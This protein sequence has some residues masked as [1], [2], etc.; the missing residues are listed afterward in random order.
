MCPLQGA[1][2]HRPEQE[3]LVDVALTRLINP[4]HFKSLY[5]LTI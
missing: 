2:G 1:E 5:D 4:L 3:S